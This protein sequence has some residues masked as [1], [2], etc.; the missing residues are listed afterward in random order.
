MP[1]EQPLLI[2]ELLEQ[3][4]LEQ[5]K[6]HKAAVVAAAAEGAPDE[7]PPVSSPAMHTSPGVYSFTLSGRIA[8]GYCPCKGWGG[9]GWWI[10]STFT[11]AIV[12]N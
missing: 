10:E 6:Q 8:E 12:C 2:E 4:K 3:E 5:L 9:N 1:Q 7:S 11:A